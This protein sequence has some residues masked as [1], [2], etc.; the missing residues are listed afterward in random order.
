MHGR[1]EDG[2]RRPHLLSRE[3]DYGM[4]V[5]AGGTCVHVILSSC[6]RR[7]WPRQAVFLRIAVATMVCQYYG[8]PVWHVT[9]V[10]SRH[11]NAGTVPGLRLRAGTSARSLYKLFALC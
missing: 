10:T 3:H 6:I 7:T 8:T 2:L 1:E 4:S 11:L 9:T 5:G